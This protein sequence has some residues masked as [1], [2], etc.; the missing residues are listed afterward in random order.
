MSYLRKK[1]GSHRRAARHATGA[2]FTLME[3]MVVIGLVALVASLA[4]PSIIAMYNAGADSQAYNLMAAQLTSARALAIRESTYAGVHVQLADA[5]NPDGTL[6]RPKLE[7]VCF[8]ASVLYDRWDENNPLV[9]SFGLYGEPQRV[10]GNIAFGKL[11]DEG[12]FRTITGSTYSNG[13]SDPTVFTTFTVVFSPSGSAVRRV[14]GTQDGYV[15]FS[16]DDPVF[17]EDPNQ[18]LTGS[19]QLWRLA[20]AQNQPPVTAMTLFDIGKYI[21]ASNPISYLNNNGQF[22]PLNVHTGQLFTRE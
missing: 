10:P 8:S 7:H 14:E 4:L 2:G 21:A 17:R 13:A 18:E 15:V 16:N 1:P 5:E 22:L 3:M 12:N 9:W 20:N 11:C 19:V 6:L